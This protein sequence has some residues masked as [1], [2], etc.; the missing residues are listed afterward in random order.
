M[1]QYYRPTIVDKDG[2]YITF[3]CQTNKFRESEDYNFY[4]GVKLTEHSWIGNHFTDA[5]SVLIYKQPRRVA[6]VGDYADDSDGSAYDKA[7]KF[8][9]DFF[10]DVYGENAPEPED[11]PLLSHF[12][13]KNKYLINHTQ[14]LYIPL[15][16]Y[17]FES[18]KWIMYPV[19]L[20]CAVGNGLGGGD[21][22]GNDRDFVGK[23]AFDEISIEDEVPDG[24][25]MDNIP[26]FYEDWML[27]EDEGIS[28]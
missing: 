15:N 14:K 18:D 21:Y 17:C 27:Q 6:W 11:V 19:S 4:N 25:V 12:D 9:P 2:K 26:H 24:F 13:Y 16:D 3:T 28:L 10:E 1:G 7:M 8:N 20:L 22:R 5:F 23:Y